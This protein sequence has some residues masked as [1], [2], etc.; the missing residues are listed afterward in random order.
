MKGDE[1]AYFFTGEGG[2]GKSKI[3]SVKLGEYYCSPSASILQ[4]ESSAE[5]ASPSL[6]STKSKKITVI[7]EPEEN[8]LNAGMLEEW[9]GGDTI[10][11]GSYMKKMIT[12]KPQFTLFIV[13]NHLPE[14]PADDGGMRKS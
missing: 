14:L 2:N 5:N 1:N 8:K 13:S 9:T 12:F 3:N 4:Q 7:Q 11:E 6:I 10:T